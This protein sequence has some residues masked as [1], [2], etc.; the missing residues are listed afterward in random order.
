MLI[1]MKN[2]ATAANIDAVVSA[3]QKKGFSAEKLPGKLRTAIGVM[4]NEKYV[5]QDQ[6]LNLEG[7]KEI[8]HVTKPY[9]RVSR[10]YKAENTLVKI[11]DDVIFGTD[12]PVIIAGPCA[13]ESQEQFTAIAE[14]VQKC[15]A[16]MLRGG[17]FKPRTSPYAFRGLKEEGLKIMSK[18]GKNLGMPIVSEILS[19]EDLPLFEK[20]V[21]MIQ[22]GA[23]NMQN[24]DLL[25]HVADLKKP[26]LL[27]RGMSAT[28]EEYLLAAEYILNRGNSKVVLCERG[29]RTF[30]NSTRNIL[31]LNTLALIQIESHLPI[32]ADPSHAAGRFDVVP[33]LAKA[34]I[35][36]GANGLIIEVHNNPAEAL[37]D[38]KQSLT[39]KNFEKLMKEL[40]LISS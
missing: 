10:E 36:A 29:I 25:E 18:V 24:F 12:E 15:G 26:I 37:S 22:I 21:D 31:D 39:L 38:G 1:V 32:I 19:L 16:K 13:V 17:A 2:S 23:R 5:E 35:A 4:G 33:L 11:N 30:E 40:N 14:Y 8:I 20:Y 3:I 34:G 28:M 27:K 9:K 6:L 7:V